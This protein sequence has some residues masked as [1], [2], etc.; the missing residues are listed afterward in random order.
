MNDFE[1]FSKDKKVSLSYLRDYKNH[2]NN[3]YINPTVI[4]ERQ[5]NVTQIDVFSR[6]MMDRIIF[7]G[8]SIDA[9]VSNIIVSQMLYLEQND[10]N[11]I[12]L[13]INS[14]GGSVYDGYAI[15]DVMQYI[16]SKVNTVC[17]GMA[18]SM[19][20]V[21]LAAGESGGR[22]AMNH[23]RIMIHQPSSG[24]ERSQASDIIIVANEISAIKN[25]LYSTL[26]FHTGQSIEKIEED[27]DRDFWMT[28]NMAKEY[29]IIDEILFKK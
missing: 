8:T 15:Y 10:N 4:E 18:A 6:L 22:Y 23:S 27:S 12:N 26:S 21:L 19:A 29:G 9:D 24:I 14:P 25:E 28:S 7:L 20:A 11:D 1:K 16:N 3:S 17:T 13:Y 5:L 2:I